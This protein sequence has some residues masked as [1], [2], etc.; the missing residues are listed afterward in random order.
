M[1]NHP[2][3][4]LQARVGRRLPLLPLE[5]IAGR[6]MVELCIDRLRA[7]NAGPVVLAT[8]V[9]REDDVLETLA[10][11][12]DVPVLRGPEHDVVGRLLAAAET[13]EIDPVI[14][15]FGNRPA[16][17]VAAPTRL[18][19]ALTSH[20]ADFVV[21][22]GM[23]EGAG[24]EVV[25]RRALR[26]AASLAIDPTDRER[27]TPFLQR[28]RDLFDTVRLVAPAPLRA[29][30]PRLVVETAEDLTRV[31]ELFF[32]AGTADAP[33]ASLVAAHRARL[34]RAS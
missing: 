24:V 17:D 20:R 29:S 30:A 1:P 31:R 7:A 16:F 32:R 8:T 25:S 33:L 10:R 2:G 9:A 18:L 19:A 27:M 28:R 15:A 11:R 34:G 5:P 4:V 23:P 3:I 6:A 22:A 12:M 14:R 21:E 13:F 26:L